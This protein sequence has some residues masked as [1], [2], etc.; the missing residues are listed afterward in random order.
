MYRSVKLGSQRTKILPLVRVKR[1]SKVW[2]KHGTAT[3]RAP[4]S[5]IR[6]L[7]RTRP[8]SARRRKFATVFIGNQRDLHH[9][10]LRRHAARGKH[11]VSHTQAHLLVSGN[12]SIEANHSL[13]NSPRDSEIGGAEEPYD[14][15]SDGIPAVRHGS[16]E[17]A[18]TSSSEGASADFAEH[19]DGPYDAPI[20][21]TFDLQKL[22]A[23][24]RAALTARGLTRR[25]RVYAERSSKRGIGHTSS[26][27]R[28]SGTH[29]HKISMEKD[30]D[31]DDEEK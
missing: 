14:S 25:G 22:L 9:G 23:Y 27:Y 11:S 2:N 5:S 6:K 31:E 26:S 3:Y 29:S 16:E 15:E 20:E 12:E 4:A 19:T 21:C 8:S 7:P 18:S 30:D 1:T 24:N 13:A 17:L 28:N 10:S